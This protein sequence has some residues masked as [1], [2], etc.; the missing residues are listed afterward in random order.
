MP[1]KPSGKP[2]GRPK[3]P[4]VPVP[5]NGELPPKQIDLN[6]VLY[7]VELQATAEEVAGSFRV[8]VETLDRKLIEAFG[9]GFVELKKRASGACKIALRNHQ[10]AQAEKN[11]TMAIWLGK[12]WLGQKEPETIHNFAP[13][14]DNLDKDHLI[15]YLKNEL[16]E[17][18][19]KVDDGDKR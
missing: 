8:T 13:N 18:K 7:W 16:A 11:A 10:F 1:R 5:W 19:K 4:V 14:Q 9:I 2:N 12:V 17:L 3:I 15:M 6:Q